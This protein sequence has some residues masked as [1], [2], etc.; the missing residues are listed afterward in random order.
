MCIYAAPRPWI[1]DTAKSNTTRS[2]LSAWPYCSSNRGS[3]ANLRLGAWVLMWCIVILST[4]YYSHI[5]YVYQRRFPGTEK[6][7]GPTSLAVTGARDT[8]AAGEIPRHPVCTRI[9]TS[10]CRCTTSP[11]FETCND[12]SYGRC[13]ASS[14]DLAGIAVAAICVSLALVVGCF[15]VHKWLRRRHGSLGRYL[16]HILACYA[17]GSIPARSIIPSVLRSGL[18]PNQLEYL[19]NYVFGYIATRQRSK[20][21]CASSGGISPWK[22]SYLTTLFLLCPTRLSSTVLLLA[23]A[24]GTDIDYVTWY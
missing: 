8:A 23:Q 7:Y 16:E 1:V 21:M 9:L 4:Y 19:L 2:A 14:I 6:G 17:R 11:T 10:Y 5:G 22:T 18:A 15:V 3:Q 12:G 24:S 13:V 20:L